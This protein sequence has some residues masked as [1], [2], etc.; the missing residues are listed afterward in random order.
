VVISRPRFKFEGDSVPIGRELG[1]A[2]GFR[3][4]DYDAGVFLPGRRSAVGSDLALRL[5]RLS[6]ALRRRA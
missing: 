3:T 1:R 4:F 2:G 6:G 5:S